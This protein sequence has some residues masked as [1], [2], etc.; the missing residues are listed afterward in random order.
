MIDGLAPPELAAGGLAGSVRGY[1][2][3]AGRTYG[4]DVSC[5]PAELPALDPQQ[6]DRDLPG[7]AG[8]D[9]QRAT[10]FRARQVMV[11]LAARQRAVVLQVSDDGG[12][13]RPERAAGRASASLRCASGRALSAGS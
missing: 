6:D 9:R 1:A 5:G 7:R 10:A 8:G 12:R 3:L 11:T 13:L 2:V 4:A